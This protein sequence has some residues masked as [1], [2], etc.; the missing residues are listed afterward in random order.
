MNAVTLSPRLSARAIARLVLGLT[1]AIGILISMLSEA[2][3]QPSTLD[4][5]PDERPVQL[6]QGAPVGAL[7]VGWLALD[8]SA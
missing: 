1:I 6:E 5:A 4:R 7:A 2:G 3:A 8:R